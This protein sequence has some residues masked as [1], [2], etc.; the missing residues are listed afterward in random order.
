MPKRSPGISEH[1]IL[2]NAFYMFRWQIKRPPCSV[3]LTF[4]QQGFPTLT[5]IEVEEA[6][7]TFT[8][9]VPLRRRRYF[10]TYRRILDVLLTPAS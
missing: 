7:K 8:S 3:P 6:V 10:V 5:S 9:T 2:L 1:P 4:A